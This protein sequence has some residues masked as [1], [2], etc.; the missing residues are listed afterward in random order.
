MNKRE[1]LYL[2]DDAAKL[3]GLTVHMVNYLE[4][5]NLALPT[6]VRG[7][8]R[9]YGVPRLYSFGDIVMLR[10][11]QSLIAMGVKV[12][13]FKRALRTI[14]SKHSSITPTSVPGRF[15]VLSPTRAEFVSARELGLQLPAS[16]LSAVVLDVQLLQRTIRDGLADL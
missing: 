2:I 5:S 16:A 9:R 12:L 6:H 8:A 3:S 14:R 4:R 15:L 13:R 11:V 7:S 10:G 1:K